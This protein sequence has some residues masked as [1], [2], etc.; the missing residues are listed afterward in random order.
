SN[1]W[2]QKASV[3]YNLYDLSISKKNLN[4]A[5]HCVVINNVA[6]TDRKRKR[7][8][9]DVIISFDVAEEQL[10][11]EIQIPSSIVDKSHQGK[12]REVGVLGQDLYLSV[13]DDLMGKLELWVKREY[14]V[15]DSWTK[16]LSISEK[17]T[18][19]L[20]STN[21]LPTFFETKWLRVSPLHTK[22]KNREIL[23]QVMISTDVAQESTIVSYDPLSGEFHKNLDI[24]DIPS[25]FIAETYVGSLIS[26]KSVKDMQVPKS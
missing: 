12:V 5:I 14:G 9:T 20:N 3:P 6:V 24:Q 2:K 15:V 23:L 7:Q 8:D 21:R 1:S 4:G 19:W 16:L 22:C 10:T 26:L 13:R 25:V 17:Q 18:N 11:R